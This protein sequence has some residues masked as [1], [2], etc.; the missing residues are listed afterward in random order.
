MQPSSFAPALSLL[1]TKALVEG[2]LG[3]PQE[4]VELLQ[5]LVVL[6]T[7]LAEIPALPSATVTITPTHA[8][9]DTLLELADAYA[10][11]RKREEAQT[12]LQRTSTMQE[13]ILFTPRQAVEITL[14]TALIWGQLGQLGT[15]LRML[16]RVLMSQELF[17]AAEGVEGEGGA[18]SETLV[19]THVELSEAVRLM[20]DRK[21]ADAFLVKAH[22]MRSEIEKVLGFSLEEDHPHYLRV[23]GAMEKS[24]E[25]WCSSGK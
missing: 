21:R 5:E 12:L 16:E 19:Q 8:L 6:Q 10:R 17:L 25:K 13:G 1:C 11:L 23:A 7:R 4:K 15:R 18:L 9:L 20:G 2:E 14:R 3:R 24:G 22:D